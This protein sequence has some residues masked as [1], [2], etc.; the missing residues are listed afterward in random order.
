M[1]S[2]F[3]K[4]EYGRSNRV[5]GYVTQIIPPEKHDSYMI[6]GLMKEAADGKYIV[7]VSKHKS[8][9]R[10]MIGSS[11]MRTV[12]VDDP[13][14][15][16]DDLS[17]PRLEEGDYISVRVDPVTVRIPKA[18]TADTDNRNNSDSQGETR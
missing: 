15:L 2:Y 16:A 5:S 1:F 18:F 10:R 8:R 9:L 6:S 11:S 14:D 3:R 13:G 17:R 4:P 7:N 12:L